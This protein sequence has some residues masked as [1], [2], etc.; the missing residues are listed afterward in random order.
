M[1]AK[2]SRY[3]LLFLAE[4]SP[5]QASAVLNCLTKDQTKA[6][7]E[8]AANLL[9]GSVPLTPSD[10]EN[11]QPFKAF[12]RKLAACHTPLR[13]NPKAITLLLAASRTIIERL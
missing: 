6:L 7:Q 13:L 8:V 4:A 3:F 1:Y 2:A 9:R 5:A 10:K 11:L 12:Y